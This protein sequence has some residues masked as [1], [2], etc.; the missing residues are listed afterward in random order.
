M[1]NVRFSTVCYVLGTAILVLILAADVINWTIDAPT[2]YQEDLPVYMAKDH[3][4]LLW[5]EFGKA[6][7]YGVYDK[8][9][10]PDLSK[11]SALGNGSLVEHRGENYLLTA[12]HCLAGAEVVRS[13]KFKLDL[14]TSITGINGADIKMIPL[15]GNSEEME[16]LQLSEKKPVVGSTCEISFFE[17]SRDTSEWFYRSIRGELIAL[18]YAEIEDMIWSYEEFSEDIATYYEVPE[19]VKREAYKQHRSYIAWVANNMLCMELTAQQY[20]DA[21]GASGCALTQ[22]EREALGVLH[23]RY[24]NKHK[25]KYYLFFVPTEALDLK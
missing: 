18:N 17:T 6:T 24:E 15:K 20:Q 16:T 12:G 1:K 14:A 10:L 22:N 7:E 25:K 2:N 4:V 8:D 3:N 5:K 23:I 19:N 11:L 9:S 13:S 21:T